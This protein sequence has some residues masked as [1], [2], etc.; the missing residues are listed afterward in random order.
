MKRDL[1]KLQITKPEQGKCVNCKRH[2]LVQKKL[3]D[4]PMCI[5]CFIFY[6]DEDYDADW[7]AKHNQL[8]VKQRQTIWENGNWDAE[9]EDGKLR[10]TQ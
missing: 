9:P 6:E 2:M 1:E 10:I 8:W 7:V 5:L 4:E 3:Y